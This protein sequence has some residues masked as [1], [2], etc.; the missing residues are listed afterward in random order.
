MD[1]GKQCNHISIALYKNGGLLNWAG[2]GIAI[3]DELHAIT[4]YKDHILQRIVF[5]TKPVAIRSYSS[6]I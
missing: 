3:T 6:V 5:F 4:Q 2:I 1:Y